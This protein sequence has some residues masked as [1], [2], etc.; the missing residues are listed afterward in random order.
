MKYK[1]KEILGFTGCHSP[2][3]MGFYCKGRATVEERDMNGIKKLW[4]VT[5]ENCEHVAILERKPHIS[6]F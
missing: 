5:C 2:E 1:G 6:K 3:M 4:R